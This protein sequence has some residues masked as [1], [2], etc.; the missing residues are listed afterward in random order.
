[1]N[2]TPLRYLKDSRGLTFKQLCHFLGEPE[3]Y[4]KALTNIVNGRREVPS[5]KAYRWAALIGVSPSAL[6]PDMYGDSVIP[7]SLELQDSCPNDQI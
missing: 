6:R 4:E 5:R 1:M 2:M 3:R 7:T